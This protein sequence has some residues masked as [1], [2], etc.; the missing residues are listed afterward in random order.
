MQKNILI[1]G[2]VFLD[3]FEITEL[4]KMS[5]ERPV[6]VLKK[7]QNKKVLGGASNVANNIKSIGGKPFLISKMANNRTYK[8]ITD[9][10]IKNQIK[11]KIV[12]NKNYSSSIKRRIVENN[13]QFCRIDDEEI[14]LLLISDEKKIFKYIKKNINKFD[15][16]IL[17]DYSKGFLTKNLLEK[18]INL[19][20]NHKKKVF[21]DP[22]KKDLEFYK[23]SNFICPNIKEFNDFLEFEKLNN[24]SKQS[25]AKLFKKSKSDAFIIT[26]GS[27]GISIIFKNKKKINISQ[28]S[29]NIYDVTG[30]GDTF[31]SFFSYLLTNDIDIINSLKIA[32]KACIKI[33]QKKHT[34]VLSFDEFRYLISEYCDQNLINL[35]LKIKLWKIAQFKIGITNGCFDI[36][37]SGHLE[38]FK[39][40]K[41]LCDK[42]VVLINSDGSIKKLKGNKRP[43]IKLNKRIE[44]IRTIKNIDDVVSFN[45]DTPLSLI[46]KI[47]PDI[48]FKGS[49]Y[50]ERKVVGYNF[51]KKNG[52]KVKIIKKLSNFS[53]SKILVS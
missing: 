31:I 33:V 51:I 46:Q 24:N 7:I 45:H 17:S 25:I 3:I 15:A 41:H 16:L 29:V 34:S 30:A 19:F 1:L 49:D 27:K 26:K 6:P 22:K 36:L 28:E 32:S 8:E 47:I 14:K 40:A 48:L 2:D 38:L 10:L 42:L 21:T 4:L 13:H 20:R 39:K 11:F 43:I 50:N 23:G 53:T 52:G 44:L 37:H 9:L 5:P 12:T 18:T 35:D